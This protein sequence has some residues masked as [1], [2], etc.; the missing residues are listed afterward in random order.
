VSQ[1]YAVKAGEVGFKLPPAF[2][3]VKTIQR[4]KRLTQLLKNG[5]MKRIDAKHFK[6]F[7]NLGHE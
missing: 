5:I 6:C 7:Q 1:K 4:K 2:I 3:H